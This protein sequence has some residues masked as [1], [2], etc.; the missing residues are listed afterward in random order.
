VHYGDDRDRTRPCEGRQVMRMRGSGGARAL[1]LG[2][3]H[4]AVPQRV[5]SRNG[6]LRGRLGHSSDLCVIS[7]LTTLE[8]EL[9]DLYLKAV[10]H[11]GGPGG[12]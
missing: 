6:R 11:G 4:V 12:G 10:A 5:A 2:P 8:N 3:I 7:V 9:V 1:E